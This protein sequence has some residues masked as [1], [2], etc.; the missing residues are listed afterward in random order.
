LEFVYVKHN[1]DQD[2]TRGNPP[3]VYEKFVEL[4][5]SACS[6]CDKK[7]VLPGKQ[8]RAL[9]ATELDSDTYNA[10]YENYR[11]GTDVADIMVNAT[12]TNRSGHRQEYGKTFVPWDQWIKLSQEQKDKHIAECQQER[13]DS[14][15]GKLR[16]SYPPHQA[17]AHEVDEVVDIDHII[18]YTMLNHDGTVDD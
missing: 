7:I 6:I 17:N 8:K 12:D 10:N 14:N 16:T 1:G 4:L 5:L 11:V 9:Y 2:I 3:L 15:N 18:A 13:M